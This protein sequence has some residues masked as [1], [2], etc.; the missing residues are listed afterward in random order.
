MTKPMVG[1]EAAAGSLTAILDCVPQPVWVVD[2]AGLVVFSNRAAVDVLGYDDPAELGGRH[3]HD[4]IHH[5]RP[6]GSPYPASECPLARSVGTGESL[7]SDDEWFVRRD[8]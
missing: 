1:E 4:M 2:G 6:D 7:S 8:G 3:S 5:T